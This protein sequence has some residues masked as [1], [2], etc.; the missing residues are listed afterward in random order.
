MNNIL[1]IGEENAIVGQRDERFQPTHDSEP[2]SILFLQTGLI[3]LFGPA[4]TN[5]SPVT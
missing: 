2:G 5:S 1:P 4:D 3:L